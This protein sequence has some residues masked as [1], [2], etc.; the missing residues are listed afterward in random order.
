M[1]RFALAAVSLLLACAAPAA[2]DKAYFSNLEELPPGEQYRQLSMMLMIADGAD[3]AL[4]NSMDALAPSPGA[5]SAGGQPAL[6]PDDYAT[7]LIRIVDQRT[8]LAGAAKLFR[9]ARNNGQQVAENLQR[10]QAGHPEL[11]AE[12]PRQAIG[13]DAIIIRNAIADSIHFSEL[14]TRPE[15]EPLLRKYRERTI[16]LRNNL[17]YDLFTAELAR[18]T[19]EAIASVG[20]K[21]DAYQRMFDDEVDA[22]GLDKK[23]EA[24]EYAYEWDRDFDERAAKLAQEIIDRIWDRESQ[25]DP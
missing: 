11:I 21:S 8:M 24:A 2:E 22:A 25:V 15:V 17:E 1:K 20:G 12:L 5:D 16:Y 18:M 14:G 13:E 23:I 4:I 9:F 10:I 3:V 7:P 19:A 6:S